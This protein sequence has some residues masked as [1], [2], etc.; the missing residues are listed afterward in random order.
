MPEP[1]TVKNRVHLDVGVADVE[2]EAARP[3]E[4]G[5][6]RGETHRGHGLVWAVM[7]DPEGNELCI[8]QPA[9]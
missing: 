2:A 7:A 8:G 4:L 9:P 5:A 3:I 1:R 6:T